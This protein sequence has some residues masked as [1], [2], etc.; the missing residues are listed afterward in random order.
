MALKNIFTKLNKDPERVDLSIID[1]LDQRKEKFIQK[2]KEMKKMIDD[3]LKIKSKFKS[4]LKQL[5][6]EH[7]KLRSDYDDLFK[8][9]SEIGADKL[10]TKAFRSRAEI[11]T[12]YASGWDNDTLRYLH[13]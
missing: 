5:I 12:A 11:S 1:D 10:G 9:A 13:K 8:K 2:N 4:E 7:D 6:N 3:I